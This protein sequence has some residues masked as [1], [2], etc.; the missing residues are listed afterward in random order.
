M[1]NPATG[2]RDG[3]QFS[4]LKDYNQF[5]EDVGFWVNKKLEIH[6]PFQLAGSDLIK[7]NKDLPIHKFVN[8]WTIQTPKGYSCLFVPPLN[9]RDDRF[10]ILSGIV[11][12][13]LHKIPVNLPFIINS[14]KYPELDTIIEKGTPIAQVIPFKRDNWKMSIEKQKRKGYILELVKFLTSFI[15]RYKNNIWQKK[16]WN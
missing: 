15:D 9:N 16:K 8:P 1:I 4:P 6:Q 13:D 14:D 7:K 2:K 10:E 11:D 5:A 12:T 3:E